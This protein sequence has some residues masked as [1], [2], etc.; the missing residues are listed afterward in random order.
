MAFSHLQVLPSVPTIIHACLAIA[1]MVVPCAGH[2]AFFTLSFEFRVID[3]LLRALAQLQTCEV[4]LYKFSG[5]VPQVLVGNDIAAPNLSPVGKLFRRINIAHGVAMPT[6]M[7]SE[8]D[9]LSKHW[10]DHSRL[11]LGELYLLIMPSRSSKSL[12]SVVQI[13]CTPDPLPR[14]TQGS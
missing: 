3:D 7:I 1:N 11:L 9:F 2:V 6:V 8:I 10:P 5:I 12:F 13:P 4:I 14:E